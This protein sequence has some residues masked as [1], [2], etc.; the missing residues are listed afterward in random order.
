MHKRQLK[1]CKRQLKGC[2]RQLKGCMKQLKGC[3]KQL[4]GY[5]KQGLHKTTTKI[6]YEAI[7]GLRAVRGN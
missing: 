3:M 7:I 6:L 1:G 5:M 2:K 4:K